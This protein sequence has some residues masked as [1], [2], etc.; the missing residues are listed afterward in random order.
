[1]PNTSA[2]G[3]YLAPA[4][5]TP[6]LEDDSLEDELQ[7]AVVGITGFS[8][9]LVRPRWASIPQKH[10]EPSVD[11]CSIGIVNIEVDA[12]PALKHIPTGD[13]TDEYQ[14]HEIIHLECSFYGPNGQ[15]TGAKL[16]DGIAVPQ[17]LEGLRGNAIVLVDVSDLRSAPELYNQQWIR[18]Y[19]LTIRFRRQVKRT[20]GIQNLVSA[21]PGFFTDTIG[22]IPV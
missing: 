21:T 19:D 3:G 17:N 13:G 2:S 14:R 10:P 22:E 4:S 6:P 20:Y 5:D 12:S 1:M 18:R 8:G 11:W 9:T 16:R 15:R 7:K